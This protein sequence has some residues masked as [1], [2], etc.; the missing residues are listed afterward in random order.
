MWNST[1]L[2][3]RDCFL[4]VLEFINLYRLGFQSYLKLIKPSGSRFYNNYI[5]KSYQFTGND[6]TYSKTATV[7]SSNPLKTLTYNPDE[8]TIRN[9]AKDHLRNKC[10]LTRIDCNVNTAI[11]SLTFVFKGGIKSP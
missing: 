1:K 3:S 4:M 6:F 9:S 7:C 5:L 11:T 8:N 10:G 2:K